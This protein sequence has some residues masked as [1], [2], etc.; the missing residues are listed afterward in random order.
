MKNIVWTSSKIFRFN[1][2]QNNW[3]QSFSSTSHQ[4]PNIS[5]KINNPFMLPSMNQT[6]T[7]SYISIN[8]LEN[9]INLN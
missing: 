8:D 5:L 1:I 3:I 2:L 4:Q 9:K 7:L 6:S